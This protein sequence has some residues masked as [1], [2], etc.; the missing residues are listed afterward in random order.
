M[1]EN[2]EIDPEVLIQK[3]N[4]LG[5]LIELAMKH[6]LRA[7]IT[8]E[9]ERLADGRFVFFGKIENFEE[10]GYGP[11]KKDA[12]RDVATKLLNYLKKTLNVTP[13]L[14]HHH[15]HRQHADSVDF[16][17]DSTINGNDSTLTSNP[18]SNNSA[19]DVTKERMINTYYVLKNSRNPAINSLLA[20]PLS[21]IADMALFVKRLCE[22]ER[23]GYK[24]YEAPS[25][26]KHLVCRLL[27]QT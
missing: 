9:E 4:V 23:I 26:G 6:N 14:H 20:N 3:Q 8:Q 7:P 16:N 5:D 10:R 24:F 12:K 11:S 25:T 13:P 22:E 2:E 19:D 1:K 21:Q 18:M 15:H 27:N 17:D